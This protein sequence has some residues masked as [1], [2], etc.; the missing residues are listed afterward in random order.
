MYKA[1]SNHKNTAV[2][3]KLRDILQ[4]TSQYWEGHEKQGKTKKLA[5]IKRD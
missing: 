4:N 5:W 3:A 2:K 1:Q